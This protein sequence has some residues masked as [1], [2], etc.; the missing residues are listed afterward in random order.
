MENNPVNNF[1]FKLISSYNKCFA[2]DKVSDFDELKNGT[3]LKND[4]FAFEAC[5]RSEEG[6][7]VKVSVKS[8]IAEYLSVCL[9]KNV[10]VSH[11]VYPANTDTDYL[12]DKKPG[13]YPDLMVPVCD[14]NVE[15]EAEKLTS[16]W[17]EAD[18]PSDAKRGTYDIEI[19]VSDDNGEL[20]KDSFSLEVVD[21]VLP[22]QTLVNTQWLH[23]DCLATYYGVEMM[24][25]RH[26]EIIETY[27][28]TAVKNGQNM[29]LMP[30]FTPALDT[31]V[32]GERPTMQLVG[33]TVN[34]DGGYD[35]DFTLVDKWI[36]MCDRCGIKYHEIAHTFT[37]WG[38][39]H[40]PKV[41]ATVDGEYKKIFGWETDSLGDEYIGFIRSY[42]VAI[43]EYMKGKGLL[44]K[45][46]FH[47]SDEPAKEHLETYRKI[48]DKLDDLLTDCACGD[49]LSSY[50]FYETGA[51][52]RPIVSTAHIE[53]FV[54]NNV[55]DLWCYY[56]CCEHEKVSNRFIAN[57]MNRTRVIGMQM[58]KFDIVGFLQWGYNFY[59]SHL[60]MKPINPYECNDGGH[61][62]CDENEG[63]WAPAGDP[64]CVYPAPDG[65]TYESLHYK[66]FAQALSDMRAMQLAASLTSKQTV[67][68]LM[69]NISGSDIRFASFPSDLD[70]SEKVRFAVNELIKAKI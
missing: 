1:E 60:S 7:K 14:G 20:A 30:T 51:V 24:S 27:V 46:M 70:F 39:E 4:F 56:C 2:E 12:N 52:R 37:Q 69:E 18:I 8:D 34:K 40:A 48:H 45:C 36:E 6:G 28:K 63:I 10:Y 42:L 58:F 29:L 66:G 61:L 31:Q 62:K 11:P 67:V 22:E 23:C 68:E 16:L 53:P 47:I 33:V 49:A 9:I 15:L 65:T 25:D 35:F 26:W 57:T 38:A 54:E 55:P 21:A 64:F 59:Y 17:I 44:D 32:G 41:M 13:Y 43:K 3:V 50:S 5:M 19:A